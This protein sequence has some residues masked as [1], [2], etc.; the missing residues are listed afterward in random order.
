MGKDNERALVYQKVNVALMVYLELVGNLA[1]GFFLFFFS[2]F[3]FP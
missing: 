1:E 3:E 2:L